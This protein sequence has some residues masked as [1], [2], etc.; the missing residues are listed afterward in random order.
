MFIQRNLG[1]G[2]FDIQC[3]T[4]DNVCVVAV[5]IEEFVTDSYPGIVSDKTKGSVLAQK[6]IYS[7]VGEFTLHYLKFYRDFEKVV[8]LYSDKL[9][10]ELDTHIAVFIEKYRIDTSVI[11]LQEYF[12]TLHSNPIRKDPIF[13]EP[14]DECLTP[15][16][17]ENKEKHHCKHN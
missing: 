5:P 7:H 9:L 14:C 12:K 17:H 16:S 15:F 4:D 6:F 2:I 11:D 3:F 10:A 8:L 1:G 13:F